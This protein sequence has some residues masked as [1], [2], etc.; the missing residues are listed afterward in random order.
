MTALAY[1]RKSVVHAGQKTL[2]WEV[3]EAEVRALAARHGDDPTILSDWGRSGRADKVHLRAGYGQ[4]IA[5]VEAGRVDVIYAYS[6]SRLSRSL[7]DYARLAELCEARGVKIRTCKEGETDFSTASGRVVTR[8]LMVV[9]QMEAELAQERSRDMIRARVARGDR[10]G[11]EPYGTRSGEDLGAVIASFQQSGSVRGAARR[12]NDA[13]V[14]TRQ[15]GKWH[16]QSVRS[17][18]AT[19]APELLPVR[20]SQGVAH[21]GTRLLTRLLR[22]HCGDTLT[23]SRNHSGVRY[24]C[25]SAGNVSGHGPASVAESI[26]LPWVKAELARVRPPDELLQVAEVREGRRD[27]I[28]EALRRNRVVYLAGDMDDVEYATTKKALDAELGKLDA[29]GLVVRLD[30]PDWES[31]DPALINAWARGFLSHVQLDETMRPS[32]AVWL[33]PD[34]RSAE[35]RAA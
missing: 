32:H 10:L 7:V 1:I 24:R 17:V 29:E 35:P 21:L 19:R 34:W 9:A 33:L 25:T 30:Q 31:D 4:V 20:S 27:E 28:V 12:L 26:V 6:L 11:R 16:G 3:Q 23:P 13:G 14:P 2:S 15:G 22:C 18:L 5:E 8:I